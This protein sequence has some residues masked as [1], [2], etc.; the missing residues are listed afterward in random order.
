MI[1]NQMKK[2]INGNKKVN[3]AVNVIVLVLSKRSVNK[4]VIK[5]KHYLCMVPFCVG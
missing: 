4:T 3:A 5:V 1:R 2:K